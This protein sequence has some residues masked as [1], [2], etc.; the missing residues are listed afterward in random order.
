MA[1]ISNFQTVCLWLPDTLCKPIWAALL[2]PLMS[3][4]VE[5]CDVHLEFSKKSAANKPVNLWK[6]KLTAQPD[7]S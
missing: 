5:N 1:T 4:L 2:N 6:T 3:D 7:P